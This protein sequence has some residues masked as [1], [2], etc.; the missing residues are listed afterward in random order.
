MISTRL[1]TIVASCSV[2]AAAVILL[3]AA[4][5]PQAAAPITPWSWPPAPSRIVNIVSA[6]NAGGTATWMQSNEARVVFT[7]PSDQWL[8]LT[9]LNVQSS[10]GAPLCIVESAAGVS[11]IKWTYA[12]P[13]GNPTLSTQTLGEAGMTFG[14]GSDVV[15]ENKTPTI[16]TARW[17]MTG[18]L[19]PK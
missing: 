17:M 15:I 19:R 4:Q 2:L 11:S 10:V 3:I 16:F 8:V 9:S 14:P 6:T 18:Y 5:A 12:D 7:V 13:N 1:A